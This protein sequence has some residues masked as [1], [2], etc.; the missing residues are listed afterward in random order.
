MLPG[1][2][3][4]CRQG[5]LVRAPQQHS[6]ICTATSAPFA[7][8]PAQAHPAALAGIKPQHV[9]FTAYQAAQVSRL[10]QQRLAALPGPAFDPKAVEMCA[11]KVGVRQCSIFP[12]GL[13]AAVT[14][15]N[16]HL[17]WQPVAYSA[18]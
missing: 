3:C 7:P 4:S 11:R 12:S 8:R 13:I 2:A 16:G 15:F 18:G 17:H 10:L 14:L 5:A 9:V 6:S 1:P